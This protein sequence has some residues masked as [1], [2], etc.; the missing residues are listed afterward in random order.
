M[1]TIGFSQK[2]NVLFKNRDKNT[3]TREEIVSTADYIAVKT[4]GGAYCSLGFNKFGCGFTS[5]AIN[6]PEWT[7][8]AGEGRGEEAER[9]LEEQNAG[10]LSPMVMISKMM[11]GNNRNWRMDKG[12]QGKQG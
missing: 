12:Y 9:L 4:K 3:A 11:P 8:L 6:A 2:P 7:K 10:F 5:A 1:C